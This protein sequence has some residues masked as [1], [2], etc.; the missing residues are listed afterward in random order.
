MK[1]G[2][3]I[4]CMAMAC[5][6]LAAEADVLVD[7]GTVAKRHAVDGVGANVADSN[8]NYWSHITGAADNNTNLLSTA[9]TASGIG[10]EVSNFTG[11]GDYNGGASPDAGLNDGLFAYTDVTDDA[12]FFVDS[13]APTVTL[14]GLDSGKTYNLVFHGARVTSSVRTTTYATFGTNITLQT[15]GAD[16]GGAGVNWN[17]DTVARIEG[18]TGVES[19]VINLSATGGFGYINAM[20]IEVIPE[21]ATLGLVMGVGCGILFVRR[22]FMM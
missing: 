16:V 5:L 3:Y 9:G 22:R 4:Q 20:E 21:P 14:S 8:G 18:I 12:L 19:T 17:D 1:K 6:V 7:F 13:L 15:S 11:P 10:L 2:F